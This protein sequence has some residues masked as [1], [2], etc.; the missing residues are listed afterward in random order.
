MNILYEIKTIGTVT[1]V[2]AVDAETGLEA[3]VTGPAGAGEMHL[4]Q[5][6]LRKLE[7]LLKKQKEQI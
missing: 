6:A 3:I 4:R 2:A 7:Y 5:L 1:R